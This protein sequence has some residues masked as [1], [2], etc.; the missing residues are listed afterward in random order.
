VPL[1]EIFNIYASYTVCYLNFASKNYE[2]LNAFSPSNRKNYVGLN[3]FSSSNY[4]NYGEL[5][6]FSPPA[7]RIFVFELFI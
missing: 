5:N 3:A 7:L 6:P 4:K 2:R 1:F